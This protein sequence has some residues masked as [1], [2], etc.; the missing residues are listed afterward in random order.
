MTV[1]TIV[2]GER[3]VPTRAEPVDAARDDP[4]HV[5]EGLDV[6]GEGRGADR[7]GGG[8]GQ[9]DT[10]RGLELR[11]GLRGVVEHLVDTVAVRRGDAREGRPAVDRLEQA[12]LLAVEVLAR[13]DEEAH[14]DLARPPGGA[15]LAD[16]GAEAIGLE[17]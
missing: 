12:G 15:D 2:P 1:H 17:R 11:V 7:L 8:A 14:V 5:G 16:R 9:L 10:R 3:S 4:G 13:A 6:A